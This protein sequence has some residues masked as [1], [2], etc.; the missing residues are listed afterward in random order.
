MLVTLL[1]KLWF[2]F[3]VKGCFP[4]YTHI[5]HVRA[6][7]VPADTRKGNQ[8]TMGVRYL[9]TTW[10]LETEPRSSA[11]AVEPLT[12]EPSLRLHLPSPMGNTNLNLIAS[13]RTSESCSKCLWQ[14]QR[15]KPLVTGNSA[16][17][18]WTGYNSVSSQTERIWMERVGRTLQVIFVLY[19]NLTVGK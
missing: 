16:F 11:R 15:W 9:W 10:V 12:V 8:I 3:R 18:K 5:H 7:L 13:K 1:L 4:A 2:L 6:Y 14:A 19:R 17:M